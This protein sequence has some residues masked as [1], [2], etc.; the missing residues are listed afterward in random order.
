MAEALQPETKFPPGCSCVCLCDWS[1]R[2]QTHTCLSLPP[3]C[4]QPGAEL[5][6]RALLLHSSS[7]PRSSSL[8]LAATEANGSPSTSPDRGIL[9][10][11]GRWCAG[12]RHG[13]CSGFLLACHS[14]AF[15]ACSLPHQAGHSTLDLST[16]NPNTPWL[17]PPCHAFPLISH[18]RF[19][20]APGVCFEITHWSESPSASQISHRAMG[21]RDQKYHFSFGK[22]LQPAS[23]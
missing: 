15:Q 22:A 11:T 19:L 12:E 18:P 17:L 9:V 7:C 14:P 23:L 20:S 13:Y 6:R 4:A 1:P 8:S 2:T 21:E 5:R 16:S 3:S 10:P